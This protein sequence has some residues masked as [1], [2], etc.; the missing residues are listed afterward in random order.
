[1]AL[2]RLARDFVAREIAPHM[3]EWEQAGELP[4]DLHRKAAD[5]GL[6]GVGFAEE[7]GGSGGDA[8][9]SAIITEEILHGGGS[10]GVCASLFTQGIALP[11]IA[12]NGG[13][14]LVER[15]VRPTL[16]GELIGSLA[17]TEP[18][19]GSDVA[20]LRTRAVLDGD[21]YVVNGAKTF[22][23]SGVRADFVT[24]A[25]RTG[26]PGHGGV[27][28]LV[29]DKATPGFTVSRRLDKMGWRCSDTAE[30][31][32][33]DV[34]VPAANLVGAENS[35]FVQIMQQFQNERIGLAVQAYATAARAWIWRS[36]GR[37]TGRR[38]GGRCPRV[39]SSGTSSPRWPARSTSRGATPGRSRSGTS[40]ARTSSPRCRWRRTRPS[41]PATSW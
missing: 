2:R 21:E 12:A 32:F 20:N 17:V 13:P 26:G 1:M 14:E 40:P 27:S 24:A 41:T 30:L 35:G 11:H 33:A 23:T 36:G 22:I 3:D 5:V 31:S 6:L 8:I 4:R 34:R 37:G 10:T 7:V 29:I 38:S 28:L 18:G 19:G 15:Y 16:A 25:V 9:D 39:R